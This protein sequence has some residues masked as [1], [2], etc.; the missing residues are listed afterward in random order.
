MSHVQEIESGT[1]IRSG[2]G[3]G[4]PGSAGTNTVTIDLTADLPVSQGQPKW[5]WTGSFS[6]PA[7]GSVTPNGQINFN[8]GKWD[9]IMMFRLHD[10]S[11]LGLA[12]MTAATEAI[13]S[14][15]GHDC[16]TQS[17]NVNQFTGI[18]FDQ[19]GNLTY[20]NKND[21]RSQ[22]YYMLRF[23]GGAVTLDPVINNGGGN[24]FDVPA[25]E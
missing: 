25:S 15:V 13:W 8:K 11:G 12:W 23:N 19:A 3:S 14:K 4:G 2:G 7:A 5:G 10:S 16:P 21:S 24:N 6:I 17:G 1:M 22:V 9:N 20:H 18:K